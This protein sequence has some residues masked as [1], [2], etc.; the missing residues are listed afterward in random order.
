VHRQVTVELH[1]VGGIDR[2]VTSLDAAAA[3]EKNAV[4]GVEVGRRR[5]RTLDAA[6][7]GSRLG[8]GCAARPVACKVRRC[9]GAASCNMGRRQHD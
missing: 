1:G 4:R 7:R 3:A 5:P 8:T 9:I 2:L 6:G